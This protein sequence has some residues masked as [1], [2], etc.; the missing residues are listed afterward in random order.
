MRAE[1]QAAVTVEPLRRPVLLR[2]LTVLLPPR[3]LSMF[4]QLPLWLPPV[5]QPQ[6]LLHPTVSWPHPLLCFT[7]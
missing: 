4:P 7:L 5:S 2:A 6:A 3:Q 1:Q